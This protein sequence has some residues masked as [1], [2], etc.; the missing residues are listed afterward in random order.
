A[1]HVVVA[2]EGRWHG[3]GAVGETEV[4]VVAEAR[5]DPARARVAGGEA[6]GRGLEREVE[7]I[8]EA[9]VAH[10]R[11][12]IDRAV[13]EDLPEE[14]EVRDAGRPRRGHDPRHPDAEEGLV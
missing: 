7:E 10:E 13:E 8:R 9:A 2:E 5:R 14:L 6:R 11:D 3:R 1:A 4:V 12:E